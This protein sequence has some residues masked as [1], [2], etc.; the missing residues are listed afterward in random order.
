MR[1][2]TRAR[3]IAL[4]TALGTAALV[5]STGTASA[6]VGAEYWKEYCDYGRAC[7]Y[8]TSSQVWN[9]PQCGTNPVND[10]FYYAKAHGNAFRVY[11]QGERWDY[12]APNSERPINADNLLATRVEVYC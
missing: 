4:T 12:V 11:Y 1:W 8:H 3:A 10:Y 9:L 2:R 7:I 6:D 5:G